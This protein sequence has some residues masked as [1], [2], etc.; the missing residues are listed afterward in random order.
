MESMEYYDKYIKYKT[1][2]IALKNEL[3]LSGGTKEPKKKVSPKLPKKRTMVEKPHMSTQRLVEK[4]RKKTPKRTIMTR[5]LKQN[6]FRGYAS[7]IDVLLGPYRITYYRFNN[8]YILFFGDW[9]RDFKKKSSCFSR[10]FD[11]RRIYI[12]NFLDKLFDCTNINIDFFLETDLF[13]ELIKPDKKDIE[14]STKKLYLHFLAS[15]KDNTS[16]ASLARVFTKFINCFYKQTKSKCMFN[17][18]N[19]HN[20]E[21]RRFSVNEEFYDFSNISVNNIFNLPLYF[22]IKNYGFG[23]DGIG[24]VYIIK[25]IDKFVTGDKVV[26]YNF[27]DMD[28]INILLLKPAGTTVTDIF[29]AY[30]TNMDNLVLNMISYL[31][32]GD[33]QNFSLLIKKT[34]EPFINCSIDMLTKKKAKGENV[35]I[36]E[37]VI[38]ELKRILSVYDFKV[39]D[40]SSLFSRISEKY[41]KL[42]DMNIRRVV[43]K[44]IIDYYTSYISTYIKHIKSSYDAFKRAN[45]AVI[46]NSFF[47]F[48]SSIYNFNDELAVMILDLYTICSLCDSLYNGSSKLNILYAGDVH[49]NNYINVLDKIV[50]ELQIK[51][52]KI[53]INSAG[54]MVQ[55]EQK[56]DPSSDRLGCI[57]FDENGKKD[58]NTIVEH[59]CKLIH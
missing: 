48:I 28:L 40:K 54:I 5:Q 51:S 14:K 15:Y 50:Q 34:F 12:H 33:I 56:Y 32:D 44:N 2:Y 20:I 26:N 4:V 7:N 23:T 18:V 35:V 53:K 59:I 36:D 37:L 47:T 42:K 22:L 29:E 58:W 10:G 25:N 43:G 17:K 9:H 11:E 55:D 8:K 13:T 38:N 31:L 46:V 27:L 3:A 52:E 57:I 41:I 21:F 6:I 30:M 39:M 24:L 1:K 49:V 16:R 19:F 45:A